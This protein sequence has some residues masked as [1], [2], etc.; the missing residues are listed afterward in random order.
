MLEAGAM[1][2]QLVL[3][4]LLSCREVTSLALD[5]AAGSAFRV[6]DFWALLGLM[7]FSRIV[8]I[9]LLSCGVLGVLGNSLPDGMPLAP[10]GMLLEVE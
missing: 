3:R 5:C 7:L 8:F 9:R 2:E 6:G 1:E 10:D 4:A